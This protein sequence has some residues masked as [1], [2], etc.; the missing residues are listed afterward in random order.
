MSNDLENMDAQEF[1]RLAEQAGARTTKREYIK[2]GYEHQFSLYGVTTDRA[3]KLS[4]YRRIEV[5]SNTPYTQEVFIDLYEF[6]NMVIPPSKYSI[7]IY[8]GKSKALKSVG[9]FD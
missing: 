4:E 9:V 8:D 2:K 5:L 3:T 6:F 7:W 1:K